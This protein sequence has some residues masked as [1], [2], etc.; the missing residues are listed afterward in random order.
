MRALPHHAAST[1]RAAFAEYVAVPAANLYPIPADYPFEKAAAVPLVFQTAW[2]GPI[3]AGPAARRDGRADHGRVGRRGDGG[4]PDR[5]ARGA[6]LR[7]DDGRERG[8]REGARGR[9]RLRSQGRRLLRGGLKATGKRGVDVIFDSVGEATFGQNL[10][11]LARGGVSSSTVRP[12]GRNGGIDLRN[13]F[14]KKF[15]VVGTTMAS[16]SE[17]EAVMKLVFRGAFEPVIDVVWPLDR[18]RRRTSAWRRA[19]SSGR[20]FW[21][22]EAAGAGSP[23]GTACSRT[24]PR[25]DEAAA[26]RRR[27]NSPV[28]PADILLEWIVPSGEWVF[29]IPQ[30]RASVW[31]CC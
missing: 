28:P 30:R 12:R 22:R 7:R 15:E 8:A 4:D 20:S 14:W 13:L 19:S 17:F 26:R 23:A 24:R 3:Y 18:A 11:A 9:R 6:R 16:R 21:C 25:S 31:T 29:S 1:R 2:R 27:A 5:E 10:R